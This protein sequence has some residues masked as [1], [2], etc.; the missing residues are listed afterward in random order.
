MK[1]PLSLLTVLLFVPLAA[2]PPQR[3]NSLVRQGML[4]RQRGQA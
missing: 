1:S 4:Q 2:L 3:R